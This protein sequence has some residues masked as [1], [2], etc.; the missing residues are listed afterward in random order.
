M[1]LQMDDRI[2]DTMNRDDTDET[3]EEVAAKLAQAGFELVRPDDIP[4]LPALVRF[5]VSESRFIDETADRDWYV[6][7]MGADAFVAALDRGL[8]KPRE[9]GTYECA[10]AA[11][12]PGWDY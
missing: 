7:Q 4:R 9:D 10:G 5:C 2:G 12:G 8:L 11:T 1:R 6:G 3:F